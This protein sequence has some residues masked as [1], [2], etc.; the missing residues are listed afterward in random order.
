MSAQEDDEDAPEVPSSVRGW[1][2]DLLGVPLGQFPFAHF[3]RR[4][5]EQR[6][7]WVDQFIKHAPTGRHGRRIWMSERSPTLE[8]L[9]RFDAR[10][11]GTSAPL[12]RLE[13]SILAGAIRAER[14]PPEPWELEAAER[15]ERAR[16]DEWQ[17]AQSEQVS[18]SRTAGGGLP[19]RAS[20]AT[21]ARARART[22]ELK[23]SGVVGPG[24]AGEGGFEPPIT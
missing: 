20:R 12:T 18:Q 21:R 8:W 9:D 10:L 11:A 2:R 22:N 3:S 23:G 24:T 5:F 1:R 13:Y 4:F 7:W 19:S 16:H 14:L 17:R 6:G 15:W